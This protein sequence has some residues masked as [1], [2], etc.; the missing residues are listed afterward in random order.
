MLNLKYINR[1]WSCHL[2]RDFLTLSAV[3]LTAGSWCQH[4]VISWLSCRSNSA[5][6]HRAGTSGRVRDTHTTCTKRNIVSKLK[7]LFEKHEKYFRSTKNILG[8]HS[9]ADLPGACLRSWG[10]W[11]HTGSR[12]AGSRY[13]GK[14]AE[15]EVMMTSYKVL[16]L[17]SLLSGFS[18]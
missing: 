11:A 9:E 18:L 4:S 5:L 6:C 17:L 16:T 14:S 2:V 3:S 13:T 7:Y 12:A 8:I 10:H 15:D 1:S